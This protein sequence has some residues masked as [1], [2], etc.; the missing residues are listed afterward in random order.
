MKFI[1][2]GDDML[3]FGLVQSLS[4]EKSAPSSGPCRSAAPFSDLNNPY[5][6]CVIV[7]IYQDARYAEFYNTTEEAQARMDVLVA[8]LNS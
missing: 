7:K 1:K 3:N 2:F 5:R 4:V 6:P 8:M